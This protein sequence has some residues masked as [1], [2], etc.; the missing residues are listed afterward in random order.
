MGLRLTFDLFAS[1]DSTKALQDQ[2]LSVDG[3]KSDHLDSVEVKRMKDDMASMK[4]KIMGMLQC[5]LLPIVIS[6]TVGLL[7]VL[8]S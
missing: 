5:I 4:K 2:V 8:E 6:K 7:K 3:P 1:S